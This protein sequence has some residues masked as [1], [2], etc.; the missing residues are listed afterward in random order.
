[1]SATALSIPGRRRF[2]ADEVT[3]LVEAGILREDDPYELIGGDLVLVSPQGPKHIAI[4]T[5][6]ADRL[7]AAYA[8]AHHVR[9]QGPIATDEYG[10]PEPDIVVVKGTPDRYLERHPGGSD[11]VL[12]V[13]VAMTSQL[14]DR[15][16]AAVYG[17]AGIP[18]YWLLDLVARK[19]EEHVAPAA[20]G[21]QRVTILS[22]TQD[23]GVPGT[24]Q[25][26]RVADLLP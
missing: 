23:V 16:K 15:A 8:G 11:V 12:A 7:R 14:L 3:K 2:T 9:V 13:E 1:M 20:Q 19:L 4:L 18:V 26:W 6:L 10:Q 24:D 25:S 5:M 21:Y 22:E 17:P